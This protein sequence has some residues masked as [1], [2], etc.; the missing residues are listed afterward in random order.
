MCLYQYLA[1]GTPPDVERFSRFAQEVLATVEV[2]PQ[3]ESLQRATAKRGEVDTARLYPY[4]VPSSYL[5]ASS[6]A[7]APKHLGHGLYVALAEDF[8]G[9]A[10]VHLAEALTS[11]GPPEALLGIAAS[12]LRRALSEQRVGIG[13]FAG[14][15]GLPV[16][17]FGP[18]WLAASCLLLPDLHAFASAQLGDGPLCAS[19]PHRDAMLIFR[20]EDAAYR[21]E[22]QALIA[23]NEAGARKPLTAE[24]FAVRAGR[25]DPL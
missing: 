6:A 1:P 22:M 4:L 13:R 8:D 3:R 12:N 14:P 20:D 10:R 24:L 11:L 23:E 18:E 16:V 9:A 5:D 7:L 21:R 19:V 25:V 15:R 17:H 2:L